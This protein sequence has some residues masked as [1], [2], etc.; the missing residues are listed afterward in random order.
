MGG[1]LGH[2]S[3]LTDSVGED[4]PFLTSASSLKQSS[5]DAVACGQFLC[6]LVAEPRSCRAD[7]GDSYNAPAPAQKNLPRSSRALGSRRGVVTFVWLI[8]PNVAQRATVPFAFP[9]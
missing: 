5:R 7:R 8:E 2:G 4:A 3:A 6:R 1:A 9:A